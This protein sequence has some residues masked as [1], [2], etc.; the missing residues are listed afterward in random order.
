MGVFPSSMK[1]RVANKR[2]D[3]LSV[4]THKQEQSCCCILQERL[5][6]SA[7]HPK[8]SKA[9]EWAEDI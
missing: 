9:E 7:M 2:E 5:E 4:I 6:N 1:Q 8:Q 3:P